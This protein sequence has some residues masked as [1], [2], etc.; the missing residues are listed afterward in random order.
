MQGKKL[1]TN[2]FFKSSRLVFLRHG[3]SE[4]NVKKIVQGCSPDPSITLSAAGRESVQPTLATLPKPQLLISSPLLRCK[5]TAEAWFGVPFEQIPI[6]TKVNPAMAEINAGI[7]EGLYLD[8]LKNDLVWQQ[9]MS[10]PASFEFP[11]GEKLTEF[12]DRVLR[13]AGA[14]CAEHGNSKQI[15][16]VITH[17]VVMR[18]LK[19]FLA[20]QDLAYL[21]SHQVTNLEQICLSDA[22]IM[23][24]QQFHKQCSI[25]DDTVSPKRASGKGHTT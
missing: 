9:W 19:C 18:V 17:G 11:G 14:I 12:S 13:G 15:T 21:W 2:F 1:I 4:W 20:D 5:Q 25:S 23:K 10:N 6:P 8:E 24:F 7:Y 16:Y 3:E 22:Q